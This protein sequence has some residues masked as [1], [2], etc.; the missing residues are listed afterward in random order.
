MCGLY[1]KPRSCWRVIEYDFRVISEALRVLTS[2]G[3]CHSKEALFL[4]VIA[5]VSVVSLEVSV[6][7]RL[8][9]V[10][11]VLRGN[12][13]SRPS[14]PKKWQ[15]VV[16]AWNPHFYFYCQIRV[17]RDIKQLTGESSILSY[18]MNYESLI[19]Q[20]VSAWQRIYIQGFKHEQ[21]TLWYGT[22]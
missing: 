3:F 4:D 19:P 22:I 9:G 12:Q 21:Q 2:D 15:Q 14:A 7:K 16:T 20:L 10:T 5:S 18:R 8:S 6:G 1:F 13:E 17:H 11:A